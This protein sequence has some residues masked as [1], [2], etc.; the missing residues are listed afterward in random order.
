MT[1]IVFDEFATAANGGDDNDLA[2]LRIRG[3]MGGSW[4]ANIKK[5]HLPLELFN[6]P[7]LYRICKAP[8]GSSKLQNLG[9]VW[10]DDTDVVVGYLNGQ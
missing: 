1:K 3:E 8:E 5:A 2:F 7:N 4:R 6:T 10:S 9:V